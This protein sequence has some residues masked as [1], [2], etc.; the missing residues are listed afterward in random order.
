MIGGDWND[1]AEGIY[2]YT[3]SKITKDEANPDAVGNE[4]PEAIKHFANLTL[5]VAYKKLWDAS[6]TATHR[7]GWFVDE[8]NTRSFGFSEASCEDVDGAIECE[9]PELEPGKVDSQ[10]LLSARG[11]LNLTDDLTLWVSGQNLTNEFYLAGVEDGAKPSIGRT[12]MG[13]FTWKFD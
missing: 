3:D 1:F 5:G 9:G 13:G 10:W 2:T 12:M 11:N 6:I 7:G 4:V 8:D